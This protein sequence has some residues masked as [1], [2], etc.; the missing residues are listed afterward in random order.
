MNNELPEAVVKRLAAAM[1]REEVIDYG[2]GMPD[3]EVPE[4]T[5]ARYGLIES[6]EVVVTATVGALCL[7]IA[8]ESWLIYPAMIDRIFGMDVHD[9]ELAAQLAEKLWSTHSDM[10]LAEAARIRRSAE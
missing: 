9:V 1:R 4:V 5:W 6:N 8:D 7:G 10:L 3:K 2:V